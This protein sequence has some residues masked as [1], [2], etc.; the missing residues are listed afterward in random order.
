MLWHQNTRVNSHQR[1]KQTR[2]RVC[3]HF[4]CELTSTITEWRVSWNSWRFQSK[5]CQIGE[6]WGSSPGRLFKKVTSWN[7]SRRVPQETLVN[8]SK[9]N[10]LQRIPLSTFWKRVP[11]GNVPWGTI[12][13]KSRG[14]RGTLDVWVRWT[15]LNIFVIPI[16]ILPWS[17]LK[18]FFVISTYPKKLW[19]VWIRYRFFGAER[20]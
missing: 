4:W 14:E 18:R 6:L 20:V 12:C 13:R 19:E 7:L 11:Q 2:F 3:F 10:L 9:V 5:N 15:A 1:W 17:I 8:G 16:A